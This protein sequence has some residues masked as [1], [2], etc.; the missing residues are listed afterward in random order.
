MT[1]PI[2][3]H[4]IYPI[5]E[6]GRYG[7]PYSQFTIWFSSNMTLL[8]VVTGAMG[9]AE[10]HLS[11]LWSAIALLLGNLIGGFF[12]ALHAVQGPILGVPQMI[13]SRGQFGSWGAVP[14]IMMVIVMYISFVA[15]NCVVG[16]E[17]LQFVQPALHRHT[18]ILIMAFLSFIP[19][20]IGYRTIQACASPL[21][22]LTT[23]VVI[24]CFVLG[25]SGH[26][27]Q[28]LTDWHGSVPGFLQSFS[29]AVLWQIAT[30]PYVSDSS[31]Y[32]P[33][34]P[35]TYPRVFFACYSGTVGGSFLAM[36]TGAF[37]AAQSPLSTIAAIGHITGE[38]GA[39]I[40]LILG[41][42][43]AFANAMDLYCSTL[44][45]ITFWHTFKPRWHPRGLTRLTISMLTVIL[46]ICIALFMSGSFN[47][48]Y[49]AILDILMIVMIP[50]T[51]INLVDFYIIQKG[52]YDVPSFFQE[53][54]G[55]YG[56]VN[57]PAI[58]SYL[59]G[60]VAGIPFL[61]LKFYHGPLLASLHGIDISWLISL[62]SATSAYLSLHRKTEP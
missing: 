53:N 59:I 48:I 37:L 2:E 4:T 11:F 50:W 22:I 60:I 28:I 57:K 6:Q 18:A 23:I 54:G 36:A 44:A 58:L 13:Q 8:T 20:I 41:L 52:H 9:P 21:S 56:R 30:A 29:I 34:N 39:L 62:G 40:V 1:S 47:T 15:S 12:M 25:L 31:R 45:T 7:R 55:R 61:N 27:Q 35:K 19:C 42:S 32:L 26:T 5:P 33:A 16:G 14:I 10:Y 17:T 46:A 51:A 3:Q 43:I 24:L 49:T 38:W